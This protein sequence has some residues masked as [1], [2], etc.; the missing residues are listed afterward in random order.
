LEKA[1]EELKDLAVTSGAPEGIEMLQSR[2]K[3][4]VI[5]FA[6]PGTSDRIR[7]GDFPPPPPP[8]R[9]DEEE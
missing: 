3:D 2:N 9:E 6:M 7:N 4:N 5:L 8:P 1:F